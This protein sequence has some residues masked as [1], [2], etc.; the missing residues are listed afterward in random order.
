MKATYWLKITS[1]YIMIIAMLVGSVVAFDW[2]ESIESSCEGYYSADALWTENYDTYSDMFEVADVVALGT[3]V[4]Q[5]PELR[6][7]LVFTRSL[8]YIGQVFSG[9]IAPGTIVPIIQTGGELDTY[10]TPAI[11]EAPIMDVETEY[12][13]F[14]RYVDDPIYGEYYLILGGYLGYVD[15]S[16][17]DV[18]IAYIMSHESNIAEY[19]DSKYP[20][21]KSHEAEHSTY[22]VTSNAT[23]TVG[24]RFHSYTPKVYYRTTVSSNMLSYVKNG[25]LAWNNG[26]STHGATVSTVSS[27]SAADV[28]VSA[29]A[30]GDT[31]WAGYTWKYD[32]YG[33][34]ADDENI[35]YTAYIGLNTSY[36]ISSASAWKLVAMHEMGHVFG[37]GHDE[38]VASTIM[39][40]LDSA[41]INSGLT[42]PTS[43]DYNGVRVAYTYG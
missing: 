3:I 7:D 5:I 30:Y 10:F 22:S 26:T 24:G 4:S 12:L 36:S 28:T 8:V 11:T 33:N 14:L 41:V 21:D 17:V 19:L 34:A 32:E 9:E 15:Y 1:I 35:Y 37:L 40:T 42:S 23:Y 16:T 13:L 43:Y 25:I 31:S 6:S 20:I 29:G 18:S 2:H 27:A 38:S 39:R